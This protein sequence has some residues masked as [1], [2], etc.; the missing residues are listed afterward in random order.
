MKS[1]IH[2][3]HVLGTLCLLL[4]FVVSSS[5]S[6]WLQQDPVH[7]SVWSSKKQA[8]KSKSEELVVKKADEALIPCFSVKLCQQAFVILE[9]VFFVI[10]NEKPRQPSKYPIYRQAFFANIF[11]KAIAINAPWVCSSLIKTG[12]C[13]ATFS[14]S[15]SDNEYDICIAWIILSVLFQHILWMYRCNG[16]YLSTKK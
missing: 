5:F 7:K 6:H 4:V 10:S 14:L 16:F 3:G 2:I 15:M 8:K 9:R 1:R 12:K 13:L 11:S